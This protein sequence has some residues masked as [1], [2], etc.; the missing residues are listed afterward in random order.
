MIRVIKQG[1]GKFRHFRSF[2][3]KDAFFVFFLRATVP[4]KYRY[5]FLKMSPLWEC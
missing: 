3:M 1:M 5:L 4:E 2:R